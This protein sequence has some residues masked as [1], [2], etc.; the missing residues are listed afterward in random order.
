MNTLETLAALLDDAALRATAIAQ[1][2]PHKV[3]TLEDAYDIQRLSIARRLD[4]GERRAGVKMGFTSRAKM[5][6]MGL[7][8][9]IWGRLTDAMHIEEDGLVDLSRFVRPRVEP[10]LAFLLRR[11]LQAN[12]T[13]AQVMAAIDAVAPA[14]EIIDSRYRDFRFTLPE[15]IADNASSSG[16]VIGPW[17]SA[18]GIDYANLGLVLT[19]NGNVIHA[20]STAALLGH[21]LRALMA[22]ARLSG[23]CG[24]PLQAGWI[25]LA[26]GATPAEWLVP[27]SH[28]WVDMQ[29]LGRA[30]FR[31]A[32]RR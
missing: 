29:I 15:V 22:A 3:L 7:S 31:V 17:R 21:P 2:D 8:D 26:G 27:D 16:F 9:V 18:A 10:E 19:F 11:P 23:A 28:V 20:G 1:I 24:E 4:R 5:L 25:V 6:Q 12:A 30:G 14:L 32:A 13:P